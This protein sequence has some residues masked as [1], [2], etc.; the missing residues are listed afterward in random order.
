MS[1]I[2]PTDQRAAGP[3]PLILIRIRQARGQR[4]IALCIPLRTQMAVGGPDGRRTRHF[5]RV[6]VAAGA[7]VTFADGGVAGC[8]ELAP[9]EVHAEADLV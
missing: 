9:A 2:S 4:A 6:A 3:N 8:A 5:T 7:E 1:H